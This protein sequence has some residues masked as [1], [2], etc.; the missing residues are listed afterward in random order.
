M[1]DTAADSSDDDVADDAGV[2]AAALDEL[3]AVNAEAVAPDVDCSGAASPAR[4]VGPV[5]AAV[6]S[7]TSTMAIAAR[8][9][10]I[11]ASA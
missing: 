5:A 7:R 1:E 6:V 9:V 3:V 4:T 11:A 10:S 2:E 8:M